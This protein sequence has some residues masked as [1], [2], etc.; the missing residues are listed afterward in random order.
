MAAGGKI[1]RRA[2]ACLVSDAAAAD[3]YSQGGSYIP[4]QCQAGPLRFAG[5]EPCA[6]SAV[7]NEINMC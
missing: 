1:S 2:H 6:G 4:R 5:H 3:K 7:T